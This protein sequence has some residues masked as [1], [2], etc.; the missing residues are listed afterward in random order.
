MAN[1]ARQSLI[2]GLNEDLAHEYQ[3][4][5]SYLLYSRLVTGPLRPELSSFLESEIE[6][7]LEHAKFLSH[8]IVALGGEPTSRPAAVQLSED[9][10]EMLELSLRSERET[11][12]RYTRRIEQV[13]EAGEL[14]LRVDLEN[15]LAE[16]TK[17]MEDLERILS[18][19][20]E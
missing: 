18:Q 6:D 20:S 2:D 10:R 11:I 1:D 3:A 16:E 17:H 8:K 5:I 19:W 4:I 7:E 9:N 14:G 13:E 12:E 15:I